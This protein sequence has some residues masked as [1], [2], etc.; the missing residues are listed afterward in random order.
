MY[1]VGVVPYNVK[2]N[3]E[4]GH[5]GVGDHVITS[6]GWVGAVVCGTCGPVGSAVPYVGV[7][8]DIYPPI[9]E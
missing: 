4:L 5:G 8:S 6:G 2:V 7:V 3:Y 1:R 9:V